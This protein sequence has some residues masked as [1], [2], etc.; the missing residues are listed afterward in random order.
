[1][2]QVFSFGLFDD[3]IKEDQN[4]IQIYNITTE[5][6]IGHSLIQILHLP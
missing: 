4:S 6:A 1:M 2:E 3:E 5:V